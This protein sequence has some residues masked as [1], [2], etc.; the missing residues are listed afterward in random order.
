MKR[1]VI[2]L[3]VVLMIIL[4][5]TTLWYHLKHKQ[6]PGTTAYDAQSQVVEVTTAKEGVIPTI[7]RTVGTLRSKQKV[8]ISPSVAG[9]VASINFTPGVF[10]KQGDVVVTL[11]DQLYQANLQQA[12]AALKLSTASYERIKSLARE[13][14]QTAQQLDAAKAQL[15]QDKAKVT[16]NQAYVAETKILAPFD[17][18]LGD[19]QINVGDTVTQG[20]AITILVDK[21]NLQVDYHLPARYLLEAK[22]DQP[23]TIKTTDDQREYAGKVSYISPSVDEETHSVPMQADINNEKGDLSPGMF[24]KVSQTVAVNTHALLI[25]AEALIP[26][27]EGNHVFR[28]VDGHANLVTVVSDDADDA[29]DGKVAILGLAVGDQ[30]VTKGQQ[31]LKDGSVVKTVEKAPEP[32]VDEA[33]QS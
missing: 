14:A 26:T 20:Q 16:A 24:V 28:I 8:T 25:P 19:K 13:G 11:D 6:H 15:E 17:G 7:I 21:T 4:A 1:K 9:R 33:A 10:V 2:F 5:V 12:M 3:L 31:Q 18:F 27:A 29:V 32:V 22:I 30:V 23:V